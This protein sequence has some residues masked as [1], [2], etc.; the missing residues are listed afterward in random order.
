[1][2]LTFAGKG[3]RWTRATES[4]GVFQ[5][6]TRDSR[7]AQVPARWRVAWYHADVRPRS[8]PRRPHPPSPRLIRLPWY[9]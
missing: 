2:P 3:A 5:Q 4:I 7:V 9:P 8:S 1:M 6:P